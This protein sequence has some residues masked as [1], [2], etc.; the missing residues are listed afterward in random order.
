MTYNYYVCVSPMCLPI[1]IYPP[2]WRYI[3]DISV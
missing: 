1:V 3:A 2:L